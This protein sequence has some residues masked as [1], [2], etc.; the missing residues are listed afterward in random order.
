MIASATISTRSMRGSAVF[1]SLKSWASKLHEQ[2][3]LNP[4]ESQRLLTVLTGSFRRQLDE[5]HPPAARDTKPRHGSGDLSKGRP[6]T[7]HSSA[8]AA[9]RHLSSILTNP[10]LSKGAGSV[11]DADQNLADAKDRL[12]KNT[13]QDPITLL[14]E[15][16]I[17]GAA[18]LPIAELCLQTYEENLRGALVE[19][20]RAS[21]QE[22]EPGRRTL[23]WLWRSKLHLA[24]AFAESFSFQ[25]LLAHALMREG[26]HRYLWD[27]LQLDIVVA[28]RWGQGGA[29]MSQSK[30]MIKGMIHRY[31]WKGGILRGMVESRLQP[32]FGD[33]PSLDGALDIYFKAVEMIQA[34]PRGSH[35]RFLP[36]QPAANFLHK[37][38]TRS[39][40]LY[41]S[42]DPERYNRFARDYATRFVDPSAKPEVIAALD[43]AQ[44][45]LF[46]P[47]TPTA[48]PM[49]VAFRELFEP[50]PARVASVKYALDRINK[51]SDTRLAWFKN[52]VMTIAMLRREGQ[53][54]NAAWLYE[55]IPTHFPTLV[56]YLDSD[57]QAM[58]PRSSSGTTPMLSDRHFVRETSWIRLR[59]ITWAGKDMA[60][61]GDP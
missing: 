7:L 32:S 33:A 45:D 26:L 53:A 40:H 34:A 9:D 57:L 5:A 25:G 38:L 2:L 29:T 55:H 35:L 14:E 8:V 58:E 47:K 6:R 20:Q 16:N 28:D 51:S 17:E 10:L 50:I 59:P 13:G 24:D 4:R 18:T 49:L 21:V 43:Q 27:W 39:G 1:R 23:M 15:Y 31:R 56:R 36:V 19:E 11:R 30:S 44:L 37:S 46:H 12:H 60:T 22:C 48:A 61:A 42:P 3:P 52:V 41:P 54:A